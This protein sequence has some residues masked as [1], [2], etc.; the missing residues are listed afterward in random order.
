MSAGTAMKIV[1]ERARRILEDAHLV[2]NSPLAVHEPEG[3][4]E[5][6]QRRTHEIY[7]EWHRLNEI[8]PGSAST[9][10]LVESAYL[11]GAND[12]AFVLA[13]PGGERWRERGKA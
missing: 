13:S 9:R 7:V 6:A 4:A 12:M 11:Q 5:L 3:I 8:S 10:L 2:S 1:G